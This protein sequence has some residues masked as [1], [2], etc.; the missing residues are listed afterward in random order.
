MALEE[1]EADPWSWAWGRNLL[2]SVR[3]SRGNYEGVQAALEHVYDF[4]IRRNDAFDAGFAAFALGI[5]AQDRG[6]YAAATSR[7][8]ESLS[9]FKEAGDRSGVAAVL[10]GL[11]TAAWLQ[12]DRGRALTL[13]HESLVEFKEAGGP[14]NIFWAVA[15][16]RFGMR[17]LGDVEWALELYGAAW[18]MPEDMG[19]RSALAESLYSLGRLAGR[20]GDLARASAMLADSLTLQG[21]IGFKRGVELALL[22]TATLARAQGDRPRA[23]RLL[24]AAESAARA[25]APTL[26]EY[27]RLEF[28]RARAEIEA[29]LDGETF[30]RLRDEGV[31]MP[32]DAAVAYALDA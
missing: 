17:T 13:Q 24:G 9:L 29:D 20:H 18:D 5:L 11:A 6:E 26:T 28:E 14:A 10:S 23:A 19:A 7:F 2:A 31:A 8:E 27:E 3:A 30:A 25:T 16:S 1:P 32:I 22:E 21:E 12:D 15:F 4:F